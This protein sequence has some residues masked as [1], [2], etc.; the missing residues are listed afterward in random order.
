MKSAWLVSPR[1]DLAWFVLPAAASLALGALASRLSG[2]GGETPTWAWI[3]L[4]LLVDVAHVHGTT[5]RV[6]L[7]PDELRRRPAL[8]LGA[9]IAGL[10]AGVG[11][12]LENPL[13]FWRCLAYLA[14]IHF[15][16]QQ[17]GWLRLYRRRAGMRE[18]RWL[19][20][21][22][23]YAAT[24]YPLLAWHARLP[25]RFNWFVPGDFVAGLPQAAAT[26]AFPI[27]LAVL[28]AFALR[29]V[30]RTLRGEPVQAGKILLVA[31]TA[32]TWAAGILVWKSDF[33][34]TATNV[35]AHGVPYMAV[36]WRVGA[37]A[38]RGF[39][40]RAAA[41]YAGALAIFAYVEEWFWDRAVWRDHPIVFPGPELP[42]QAWLALLV[43][44]LALPQLTHYV[45]D[46]WL[47][48]LDGSNPGLA[49]ALQV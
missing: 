28:A 23:I 12:Y 27:Y 39:F 36:S 41:I 17:I 26:V 20:E 6:Y 15:V 16:R 8:Y 37:H 1:F 31:S 33:A 30:Q 10:V 5:V 21:A 14:V 38:R 2:P 47:W 13:L 25:A 49:E 44:L 48:R 11:L 34:F 4:V 18:D 9:P 3:A 29:Q 24:G 46:A 42:A 22:A 35:L 43:P 45:L 40:F 32:A 19:D 7:S